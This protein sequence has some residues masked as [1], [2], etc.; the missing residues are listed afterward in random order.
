MKVFAERGFHAAPVSEI[1]REAGVSTGALY[2]NF[3]SKDELFLALLDEDVARMDDVLQRTSSPEDRARSWMDYLAEGPERFLL[4]VEFW[5]YALRKPDVLP[6]FRQRMADYRHAIAARI[7][8]E[9]DESGEE[10]TWPPE[11][12]ALATVILAH[13]VALEKLPDPDA[14]PD[15]FM[16]GFLAL[17]S[18]GS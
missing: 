10:L 7:R 17:L 11:L 12:L 14:V 4:Y 1:A 3:A 8:T 6:S 13:G 2:A 15:E 16:S 9:A 18:R 5:A